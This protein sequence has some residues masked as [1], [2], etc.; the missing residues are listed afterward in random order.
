MRAW[1]LALAGCALTSRSAPQELR[2]FA[3]PVH[4]SA[5]VA[6]EGPMLKLGR[7]TPSSLLRARI[8]HRDSDVELGTYEALRWGDRPETYVRRAL[9]RALFDSHRFAQAIGGGAAPTLDVDVLAFEEVRRGTRR[10]GR[11]ALEYDVRDDR[12][13]I[14]HGTITTEREAAPSIDAVVAAIGDALDASC[15][16]LARRV[17]L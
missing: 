9:E 6:S 4:A 7:V 8:V 3:P 13:V 17:A 12:R 14:A 10:F 11:V 15:A 16:E 2:Y 5:V 1:L